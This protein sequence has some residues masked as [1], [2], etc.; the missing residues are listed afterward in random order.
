MILNSLSKRV[1]TTAKMYLLRKRLL[2]TIYF[3]KG[4]NCKHD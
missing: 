1:E 2:T 4:C 3:R